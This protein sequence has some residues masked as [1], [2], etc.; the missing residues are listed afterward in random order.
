MKQHV[1]MCLLIDERDKQAVIFCNT[2]K[3]GRDI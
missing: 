1:R 3:K 2:Q